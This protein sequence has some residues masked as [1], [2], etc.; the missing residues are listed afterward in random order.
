MAWLQRPSQREVVGGHGGVPTGLVR[1]VAGRLATQS[2]AH[3]PPPLWPILL[4]LLVNIPSLCEK[5]RPH[6]VSLDAKL[7]QR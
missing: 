1:S 5:Q 4:A 6:P 7:L 3:N 2:N